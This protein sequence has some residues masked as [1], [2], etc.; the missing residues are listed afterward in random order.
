MN[1]VAMREGRE[2]ANAE[3]QRRED[4]LVS[5]YLVW[6]RLEAEAH[7]DLERARVM[8]GRDAAETAI[9]YTDWRT[10]VG[11]MPETPPDSAFKR[12]RNDIPLYVEVD[13]A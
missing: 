12:A 3:R 4:D 9:A 8:F 7:A 6:L 5:E 13:H 1:A 2:R 10:A 11:M